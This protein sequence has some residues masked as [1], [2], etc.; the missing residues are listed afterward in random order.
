MTIDDLIDEYKRKTIQIKAL[1]K[2]G[3]DAVNLAKL[4]AKLNCYKEFLR[5]LKGLNHEN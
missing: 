4:T 3:G 1:L 2:N 5:D